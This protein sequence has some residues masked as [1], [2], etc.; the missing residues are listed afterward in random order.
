[1]NYD[2]YSAE[3]VQ[4][5]V[6]VANLELDEPG[7]I[8][9]F[10]AEH[11]DWFSERASRRLDADDLGAIGALAAGIRAVAAA[12]SDDDVV[13]RLN[14]LL[15]RCD[16]VPRMTNHDNT[17]HL[18]YSGDDVRLV[19]QLGSTASMAIALLSCR[20][21]RKRLGICGADDCADVFV[22]TSRNRSKRYCTETCA[23]RT[24]VSAYRARQKAAESAP[25]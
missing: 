3:S 20:Y 22:D 10:V 19:D 5:A 6:D 2:T 24:T 25:A 21:G 16:P 13:A 1:M 7:A 11:D 9:A 23:S 12:E 17:L 15:D 18:H 4:L 14:E 8:D